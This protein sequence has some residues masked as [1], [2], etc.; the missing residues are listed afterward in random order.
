MSLTLDEVRAR[1]EELDRKRYSKQIT[2]TVYASQ[3]E[4]ILALYTGGTRTTRRSL[5]K[6]VCVT[7]VT[8][9]SQPLDIFDALE[10]KGGEDEDISVFTE[11]DCSSSS[12]STSY[13]DDQYPEGSFVINYEKDCPRGGIIDWG[14]KR[15]APF[16]KHG[17]IVPENTQRSYK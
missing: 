1:L 4:G 10:L 15:V 12:S 6:E 9:P 17:F 11:K 2:A 8:K 7:D 16:D 13:S 14:I 3:K 5:L